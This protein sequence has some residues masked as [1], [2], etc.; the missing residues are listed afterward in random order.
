MDFNKNI[1]GNGGDNQTDSP[2]NNLIIK[3]VYQYE[4]EDEI[5]AYGVYLDENLLGVFWNKDLARL[6]KNAANQVQI[7]VKE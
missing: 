2:L 1:H 4:D 7:I 6:F 3:R 5:Q